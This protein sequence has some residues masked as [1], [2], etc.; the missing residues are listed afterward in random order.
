LG[1]S[2]PAASAAGYVGEEGS[3]GA[4]CDV[5]PGIAQ[6]AVSVA[7]SDVAAVGVRHVI[8]PDADAPHTETMATTVKKGQQLGHGWVT[9]RGLLGIPT[10]AEKGQGNDD[11]A[12]DRAQVRGD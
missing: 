1:V 12:G 3:F 9:P 2:K 11:D 6:G 5:G 10:T 8:S 7:A 4:S